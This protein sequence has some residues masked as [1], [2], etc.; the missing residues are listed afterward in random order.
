MATRNGY[1]HKPDEIDDLMVALGKLLNEG[2]V[3][4][5]KEALPDGMWPSIDRLMDIR[6]VGPIAAT[7]ILLRT[8]QFMEG[9][10]N[11]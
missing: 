1:R 8:G 5:F 10:L 11:G 7:E 2:G 6:K 3:K 9:A 4:A